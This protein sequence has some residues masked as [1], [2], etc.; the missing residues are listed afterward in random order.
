MNISESSKIYESF[1]LPF[2]LYCLDLL[3]IWNWDEQPDYPRNMI[4]LGIVLHINVLII[5]LPDD[6]EMSCPYYKRIRQ[7]KLAET[8]DEVA[9]LSQRPEYGLSQPQFFQMAPDEE[10]KH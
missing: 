6:D 9:F 4:F 2:R 5:K 8:E 3:K 7:I 10:I 1:D